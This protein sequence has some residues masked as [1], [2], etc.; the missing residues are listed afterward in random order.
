MAKKKAETTA[1]QSVP[2]KGTYTAESLKDVAGKLRTH[3]KA[4]DA[5]AKAMS[6]GKI[7]EVEID[8]HLMLLR[9]FK[10]VKNFTSH[11]ARAI[12]DKQP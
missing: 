7:G 11:G 10:Q 3:A 12:A 8:G 4:V 5:L 2:R 9:A 1:S 6:D